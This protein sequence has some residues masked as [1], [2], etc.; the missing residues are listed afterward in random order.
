MQVR[1]L[2]LL[3]LFLA[4]TVPALAGSTI[5]VRPGA[6]S[7]TTHFTVRFRAPASTGVV[8]GS[9]RRY[10]VS[11]RGPATSRCDSDPS[12]GA[13]PAR[14][15]HSVAVVLVP[16][17]QGWCRGSYRGLIEE[18]ASPVCDP[19]RLCPQF[20]AVLRRVGTFAFRVG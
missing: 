20:I 1:V 15:G 16:G 4:V 6:G 17:R 2:L 13:P 3:G 12:A 10:V 5:S 8:N 9:D 7:P 18:F 11:A 14:A 19:H